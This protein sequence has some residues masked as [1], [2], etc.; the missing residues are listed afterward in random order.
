[1]FFIDSFQALV[2]FEDNAQAHKAKL[3]NELIILNHKELL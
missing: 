2:Q 1:M 3:V